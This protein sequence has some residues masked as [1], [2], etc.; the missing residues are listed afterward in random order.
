MDHCPNIKHNTIKLLEENMEENLGDLW[1]GDEFSHTIL[2][3][4]PMKE[5][6][7]KFDLIKI[8]NI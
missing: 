3:A 5:K 7:A 1:F 8:K 2:K 4:Q 6:C